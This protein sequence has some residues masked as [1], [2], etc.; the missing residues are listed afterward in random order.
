MKK[1]YFIGFG[2]LVSSMVFSQNLLKKASLHEDGTLSVQDFYADS[3]YQISPSEVDP[4]PFMNF[5]MPAFPITKNTRGVALA[6][7][8]MDGV[9]EILIGINQTFYALKGDG[10]ILFEK[11]LSGAILL[12]P[13]VADLDSDG[14][15]EVVINCGYPTTVG[16]IYVLDH[17]G[18]DLPGWPLSF[19]GHWMINA[20]AVADLDGDDVMEIVTGERVSGSVG[21]VHVLKL[22]G[23]SFNENW[24]ID[25]GAT[26]AFTPSIGDVDNDGMKD[27]VIAGSSTGMFVFKQDGSVFSGFPVHSPTVSYSYQSP[28]LVDLDGDENLEIVGANHGDSAAFY[29]MKSDGSYL[30]GWPYSLSGWTYAPVTVADIDNDDVYEVY[31]GNPN[32]SEGTPLPTIYGISPEG[33]DLENFPIEKI[34]GNEGMINIADVN[35]DGVYELIFGSNITDAEGNGYIHA[36]SVDGS[37]EIDGFPLRPKGFTFLNGAVLGDVDDDGLM[38]LT[39]NSYTLNFGAEVDSMYVNSYNLNV[40]FDESKILRNGYKGSNTRDGLLHEETMGTI[41]FDA[42]SFAVYPNPSNG[43][44][45][46]E[47]Q[48]SV[49]KLELK[50]FNLSGKTVFQNEFSH[51][52]KIQNLNLIHLPPGTYILYLNADGNLRSQ[53][54]IKK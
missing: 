9:D 29:A 23:T 17:T 4:E 8:D 53:K 34:G 46:I 52:S 7:L 45:N 40:P 43:N 30:T 5:G 33:S 18:E 11:E 3:H 15:L 10:T 39:A 13:T 22:D 44:L 19:D 50:I 21:F 20:P 24:P 27:I 2:F 35:E 54:W 32:F 48:K 6:D 1:I 26:P 49:K 12:P 25:L 41:D 16:G 14:D 51:S 37:G 38:D 28:I 31:G 42:N 36:F 47:F